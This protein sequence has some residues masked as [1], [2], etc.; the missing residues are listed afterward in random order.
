MLDTVTWQRAGQKEPQFES[1]QMKD[2]FSS[3]KPT[4]R[5]CNPPRLLFSVYGRGSFPLDKTAEDLKLTTHI[6]LVLRLRM[7]GAIPPFLIRF[8]GV[9]RDSKNKQGTYQVNTDWR[10]SS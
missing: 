8:R 4:D 5:V 3:P 1:W 7:R 2:S 10:R 6:H 9:H